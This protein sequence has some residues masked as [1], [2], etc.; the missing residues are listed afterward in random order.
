MARLQ[1]TQATIKAL[2]AKSGNQCAFPGC[3]DVL[4]I[5]KNLPVGEVCHIEAAAPGGPRYNDKMS[6]K[7]RRAV[8]NLMVLCHRH[9]VEID[10]DAETYTPASLRAMKHDHEALFADSSFTIQDDTLRR[11]QEE[12]SRYWIGVER[13]NRQEHPILDLS[14]PIDTEASAIDVIKA[15]NTELE[16]LRSFTD[17]FLTADDGLEEE[18][19]QCANRLGWDFGKYE[20]VAYYERPFFNRNWELHNLGV[21]NTFRTLAVLLTQLKIR[22]LE[23]ALG[24]S[25]SNEDIKRQLGESRADLEA[26]ARSATHVD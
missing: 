22:V 4:V 26:E 15:I 23:M 17:V 2:F 8:N 11:I 9:H 24:E 1:P 19:R 7:D 6:D 3:G 20:A 21:P 14:V 13:I 25:P 16:R 5:D 10:S 18:L 12:I